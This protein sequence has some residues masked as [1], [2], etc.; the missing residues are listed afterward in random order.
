M[1]HKLRKVKSVRI[2]TRTVTAVV[3]AAAAVWLFAGLAH[4][5]AVG[6]AGRFDAA[7]RGWVHSWSSPALTLTMRFVTQ[8]GSLWFLLV[9][10]G[11]AVWRV[12]AD[13]RRIA[14]W[15]VATAAGGELLDQILKVEFRRLRPHAFFG[16]ADP[17]SYSF[18]S[19]HSVASFCFY[20]ALAV[21]VVARV[22]PP[23]GKAAVGA[24]AV[25]VVL[26]VGLSRVYLG[27]HY[28]TDVVG[29]YLVA[30]AWLAAVEAVRTM[31]ATGR[32]SE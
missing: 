21:L 20:G 14:W 17:A 8:M 12:A 15:F 9:A 18:P 4:E 22:R 27:V 24:G 30:A 1:W 32:S 28:P 11:V 6:N 13:K 16:L 19:G 7:V 3:A 26:L 29:G 10:G 25:V 5:V 23:L 31:R 2:S